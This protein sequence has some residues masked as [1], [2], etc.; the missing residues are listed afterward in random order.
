MEKRF[1]TG[2]FSFIIFM[3]NKIKRI[4]LL[5]PESTGKTT[6]CQQLAEHFNT[7]WI[8]EYSREHVE[9]LHNPYTLEDIE[10]CTRTQLEQEDH[11]LSK[12]NHF[13]F[14]DT[15]LIV[16]KVWCED[17]FN[18]CPP[19]IEEEI[20]KRKY[21]LYLLTYPDLPFVADRVRENPSR[22]DYFYELYKGELEKRNFDY[23]IIRGSGSSRFE[24]ARMAITGK[25]SIS[26]F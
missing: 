24:A 13:I 9:Q 20:T 19:W 7:L 23:E 12:A 21:D 15:E 10:F 1:A 4:S 17:V 3:T 26:G 16:A 6:L 22:R 8:P 5:G 25:F 2:R 14:C 11:S 18:I